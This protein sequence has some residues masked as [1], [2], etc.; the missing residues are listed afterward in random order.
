MKKLLAIIVTAIIILTAVA[1]PTFAYGRG[2]R[3]N[4]VDADKNSICDNR[5]ENCTSNGSSYVDADKDCICDNKPAS[6]KGNGVSYVDA[7]KNGICDN[8]SASGKGTHCQRSNNSHC[9]RN[10]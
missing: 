1:V 8:K 6:G 10:R 3:A 2:Q 9:G 5:S 7:D 4:F